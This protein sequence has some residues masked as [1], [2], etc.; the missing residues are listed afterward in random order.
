MP[1]IQTHQ[2]VQNMARMVTLR[3]P[4]SFDA[5]CFQRIFLTNNGLNQIGGFDVLSGEDT[6]EIDFKQLGMAKVLFVDPWQAS[7]TI[8]T[9][10]SFANDERVKLSALIEPD[11]EGEF[12]L[13][14][15]DIF[16]IQIDQKLGLAYEIIGIELPVGLPTAM[17]AK[18]YIINKRDDLDYIESLPHGSNE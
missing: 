11:I 15:G 4:N 8:E 13:K 5:I 10:A 2:A 16:Y 6:P 7:R 18:R 3:H 9:S 14:K 12:E 17:S 1:Q